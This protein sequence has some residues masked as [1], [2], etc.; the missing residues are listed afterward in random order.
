MMAVIS[1]PKQA[2]RV[3]IAV[4]VTVPIFQASIFAFFPSVSGTISIH[5][6]QMSTAYD[7]RSP[8]AELHQCHPETYSLLSGRVQ[9]DKG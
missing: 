6:V 5:L 1:L 3:L 7:T 2:A 8:S 4:R 9:Y